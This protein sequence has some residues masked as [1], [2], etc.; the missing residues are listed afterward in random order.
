MVINVEK[1][2]IYYSDPLNDDFASKVQVGYTT[3][4]NFKYKKNLFFRIIADAIYYIIGLP[5]AFL[6]AKCVYHLKIYGKK[7]LKGVRGCFM[8]ANHTTTI[9]P[10]YACLASYPRK[11]YTVANPVISRYV[12]LK[13]IIRIAGGIPLPTSVSQMKEF[14][15]FQ[16][17][18]IKKKRDNILIYPE[19]HV[20]EYYNQIR[21]FSAASFKYPAKLDC[22]IV[23]LTTVF[24]K[25]KKEGR[26]PHISVYISKPIY[27][28]KDLNQKERYIDLRNQAYNIM[29]DTVKKYDSYEYIKYVYKEKESDQK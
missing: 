23:V 28:N 4:T 26:K 5:I 12:G 14:I 16:E 29:C 6:I 9:D 27:P 15:E 18:T 10:F 7:N 19:A 13:G 11:A 17:K 24:R 2:I 20:W 25:P 1:K 22:P 8:Y 3:P 21:P